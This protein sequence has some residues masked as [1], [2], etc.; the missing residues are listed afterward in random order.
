MK[1]VKFPD[2]FVDASF[3]DELFERLAERDFVNTL[4]EKAILK[5]SQDER[6][7]KFYEFA[8]P[9]DHLVIRSDAKG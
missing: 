3:W 6:F 7:S 1:T 8:D 5:M 4:G 2:D 9:L